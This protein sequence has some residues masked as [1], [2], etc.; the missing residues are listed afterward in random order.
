MR[1]E[2]GVISALILCLLLVAT[3]EGE[4]PQEDWIGIGDLR[5][6]DVHHSEKYIVAMN[7][8]PEYAGGGPET[9]PATTYPESQIWYLTLWDGT[10]RY[11][12]LTLFQV[13]NEI[14]GQGAM[15]TSGISQTVTATGYLM[16]DLLELRIFVLEDNVMY[17]LRMD[18]AGGSASGSYTG[19]STTGA[20]WFGS[21]F[22]RRTL[23][24]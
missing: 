7:T 11:V 8:T 15:T 5:I 4:P 3:S 1:F 21:A 20:K 22:G 24:G 23:V 16:A 2:L 19:Y 10:T 13:E 18:F 12:D 17:R 9:W 6:V 14:F